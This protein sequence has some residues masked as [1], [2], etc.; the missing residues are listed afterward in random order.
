MKKYLNIYILLVLNSLKTDNYFI[1][2]YLFKLHETI[3]NR[4]V[5]QFLDVHLRAMEQ[6]NDIVDR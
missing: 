5:L 2:Y 6:K 4:Y 3:S 1:I